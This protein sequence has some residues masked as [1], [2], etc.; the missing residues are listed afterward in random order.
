MNSHT[1]KGNAQRGKAPMSANLVFV[2]FRCAIRVKAMPS[3]SQISPKGTATPTS[4]APKPFIEV[5]CPASSDESFSRIG[6]DYVAI[7]GCYKKLI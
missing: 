1:P 3:L 2:L 7:Q 5:L 4:P 6:P